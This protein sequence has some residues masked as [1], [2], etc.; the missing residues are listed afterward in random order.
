MNIYRAFTYGW[1]AYLFTSAF[2]TVQDKI[3]ASLLFDFEFLS[4][5]YICLSQSWSKCKLYF[6]KYADIFHKRSHSFSSKDRGFLFD[7]HLYS[8]LSL[9]NLF[10]NLQISNLSFALNQQFRLAIPPSI[11]WSIKLSMLS[12]AYVERNY[13]VN[14]YPSKGHKFT[15]L[16]KSVS[17]D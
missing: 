7:I 5:D 10:Y 4:F 13:F 12:A 14:N 1:K 9:E 6:H 15:H 8:S 11:Q 3:T 17:A 2:K 16:L